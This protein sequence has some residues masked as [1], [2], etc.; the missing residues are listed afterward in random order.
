MKTEGLSVQ[1][2]ATS[3]RRMHPSEVEVDHAP[4]AVEITSK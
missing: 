3:N 1:R 2:L 4:I